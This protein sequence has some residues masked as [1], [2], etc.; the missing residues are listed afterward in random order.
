MDLADETSVS[1]AFVPFADQQ[2]GLIRGTKFDHTA[3][4][5]LRA[6]LTG[7]RAEQVEAT[8]KALGT[9]FVPSN[10]DLCAILPFLPYY[11]IAMNIWFDDEE[12]PREGK[13]LLSKSASHYLTIE[14]AVMAGEFVSRKLENQYHML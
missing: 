3:A 4:Q 2:E 6:F 14:D 10:A 1:D 8:L 5:A 7:K 11:P 13:L 12:F 9:A